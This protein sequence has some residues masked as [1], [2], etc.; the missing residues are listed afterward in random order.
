[1]ADTALPVSIAT[2]Q[3]GVSI[4]PAD[5]SDIASI[6]D[7]I[8]VGAAGN[9]AFWGMDGNAFTINALQ[10]GQVYSFRVRRVLTTG[11]TAT[12]IVGLYKGV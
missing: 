6:P 7:G 12:G 2:Y 3:R 1:M 10:P 4:T 8:M 11:T 5:D 9:V